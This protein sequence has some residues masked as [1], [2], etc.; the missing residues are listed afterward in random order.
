MRWMRQFVTCAFSVGTLVLPFC[1]VMAAMAESQELRAD[2]HALAMQMPMVEQGMPPCCTFVQHERQHEPPL[3]T[4]SGFMVM[5]PITS[6]ARTVFADGDPLF[7]AHPPPNPVHSK[8]ESR[9]CIK[10]E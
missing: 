8:F 4:S 2:H 5:Q 6:V 3:K 1:P 10:R 9:S 7:D